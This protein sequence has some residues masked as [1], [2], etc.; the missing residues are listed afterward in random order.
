MTRV[1]ACVACAGLLLVAAPA[2]SSPK[3]IPDGEGLARAWRALLTEQPPEGELRLRYPH[4]PCF[5]RAAGESG[6]PLSLLLAV[7]RGESDFDA[8]ARSSANA[9]GLMQIQWPVT[10]RHLG[11]RRLRD[12][13]D[14]CT[15]VGAGARYLRELLER[16][17]GDLHL[18]LAAYNYGPGRIRVD[19][20]GNDIPEGARWYSGYIYRHLRYV[21]ARAAQGPTAEAEPYASERKLEVLVFRRP[22]RAEG[23]VKYLEA[24]SPA[25][26]LD[27]FRRRL[28]GFSVV[29]LYSD[30]AERRRGEQ[31]LRRAGVVLN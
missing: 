17:S 8:R 3:P 14:P 7:A 31:A 9:Y 16:Y 2:V 15:N 12:L 27:W 24:Q 1:W 25:L 28:G 6:L 18:A 19:A 22:F 10:A 4:E 26:R 11:I 30:E 13:Y 20:R 23:M 5:R 21:R 29:L